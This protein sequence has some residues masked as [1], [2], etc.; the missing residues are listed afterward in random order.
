M[1]KTTRRLIVP[2]ET[3]RVLQALDNRHLPHVVGG[4]SNVVGIESAR[5]CPA[6]AAQPTPG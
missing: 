4:D 5:D 1:K 2:R 3:V 6:H